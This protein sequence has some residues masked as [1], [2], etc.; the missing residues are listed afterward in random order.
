MDNSSIKKQAKAQLNVIDKVQRFA[1]RTIKQL[2]VHILIAIIIAVIV[3]IL[4]NR[5]I[6]T[7]SFVVIISSMSAASGVLLA[8][9]LALANFF[10]RHITDWRD[11]LIRSLKLAQ[12]K[13]I[14]QMEKSAE[15]FSDISRRLS[16]LYLQYIFYIPGQVIEPEEVYAADRIFS[17]WAK[18]QASKVTEKIDFGSLNSY[19]SYAKHLLDAGLCITEL[20]HTLIQLSVAEKNG[21]SITTFSPLIITWMIIVIL[22]LV[23]A[24]M[25][26]ISLIPANLNFPIL[27]AP[28]YLFLIAIFALTKDIT[29]ILSQMRIMET[30]YSIA[31]DELI[32]KDSSSPKTGKID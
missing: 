9:S 1:V 15:L 5:Q 19:D 6:N 27:I 22:T 7:D 23:L 8:V 29:A 28:F 21:R 12:E 31:I 26:G 25:G 17:D 18:D 16:V 10:S 3:G 4:L 30:G 11:Q 24:I 13:V 32:N 14:V 20:R 2:F